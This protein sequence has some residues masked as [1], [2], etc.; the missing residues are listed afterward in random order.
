VVRAAEVQKWVQSG[1]YERI[2]RGDYVRRG[3]EQEE[4]PLRDDMREA[5]DHY[6][7]EIKDVGEHLKNAA[8]RATERAKEAFQ[9]ARSKGSA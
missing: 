6:K 4:R 7:Q 5:A 8:K 9:E 1:D 2:L 3:T